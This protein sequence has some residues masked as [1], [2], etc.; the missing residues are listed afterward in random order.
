ML[1]ELNVSENQLTALP[2][3]I[4]KLLKLQVCRVQ[5]AGCRV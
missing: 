5:G 1:L 3:E 2:A 4:G